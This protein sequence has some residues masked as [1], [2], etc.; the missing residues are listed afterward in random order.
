MVLAVYLMGAPLVAPLVKGL[1]SLCGLDLSQRCPSLPW[2][3]L[4][5]F[6]MFGHHWGI[7]L[8][9][10][11]FLWV[12]LPEW[13]ASPFFW[14]KHLDFLLSFPS[15]ASLFLLW[16][17]LNCLFSRRLAFDSGSPC[18]CQSSSLFYPLTFCSD[19]WHFSF[20][21]RT[22]WCPPSPLLQHPVM[23]L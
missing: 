1:L 10:L 8:H 15:S 4:S 17:C 13:L 20:F 3:S 12:L 9:F 23:F 7:G 11:C 6:S 22:L 19:S 5:L 16:C 21:V 2:N 18:H 14:A